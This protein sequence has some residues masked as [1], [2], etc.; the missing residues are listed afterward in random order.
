MEQMN[1]VKSFVGRIIAGSYYDIQSVRISTKNRIR[2]VIRKKIEGIPFDE[3][4]EKKEGDSSRKPKYTDAELLSQWKQLLDEGK[5]TKEECS[6]VQKCWE[7]A[8]KTELIENSYKRKM[9]DYIEEIPVY[10]NFLVHIRGIGEVLSAN[11]IKEFKDCSSFDTVSKLW[12]Y[13]GNSVC[14]DG[15][16]PKKRKGEE[17]TYSPR[18]RTLT[19]KISDC[20]MK[21]N[22]GIYRQ[23]YDSTKEKELTKTYAEAELSRKYGKPYQPRDIHLKLGH[24]HN[25]ALRKMRK[26]FLSHYWEAA[27]S[28]ANLDTRKVYVEEEL[29]HKNIIS[30]KDAIRKETS[31]KVEI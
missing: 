8:H 5:I 14:G 17:I 27:R 3:V 7:I 6:Y 29:G 16:A 13:T 24:A 31:G 25:R 2:D 22:K 10:T 28:M 26:L 19:W 18:L 23:V 20:L 21:S 11:L 4:E 12:A 1:T 30:F 15:R 9:L